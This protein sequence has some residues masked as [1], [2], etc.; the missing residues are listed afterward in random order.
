M[1]YSTLISVAY[2]FNFADML[3]PSL[4]TVYYKRVMPTLR[5]KIIYGFINKIDA[6]FVALKLTKIP[7]L[8][9]K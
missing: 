2:S 3:T 6:I 1:N 8:S 4:H 5:G 9:H 7:I